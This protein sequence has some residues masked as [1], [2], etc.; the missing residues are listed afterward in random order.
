MDRVQWQRLGDAVKTFLLSRRSREFLVFA[1]FLCVSAGFWL[2]QTLNDTYDMDVQ[3]PVVLD[4]VPADIVVTDDLPSPIRVTLRDKGTNLIRYYRRANRPP[5]QIDFRAHQKTASLG[6]VVVAQTE[7]QKLLASYLLGSS[8]ILAV[9]PDTIDY[10]FSHG[11]QKRIPVEIRGQVKANPLYYISAVRC[12]PDSVTVWAPASVLDTITV[13]RTED[14]NL[15]DLTQND[16][17]TVL[18][19]APKG[20]KFEPAEV[21]LLTSVDMYTEKSVTVPIVGINFPGDKS[22]ITFPSNAKITFRIGTKQYKSVTADDFV[23][24]VTYEELLQNPGTTFH[25]HVRS[26]PEGVS[27]VRISPETVDYLIEQADND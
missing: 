8:R 4:N 6:H 7:V 18:L 21:S 2:I 5:V 3:V 11:I 20:V 23:V 17:R 1:F 27:Q 15:T 22:L 16:V 19:D 10:Y 25:L 26:I 14:C 24:A 13:A 9:H 12:E